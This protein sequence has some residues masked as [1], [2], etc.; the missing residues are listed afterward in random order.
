MAKDLAKEISDF[1]ERQKKRKLKNLTVNIGKTKSIKSSNQINITKTTTM[2]IIGWRKTIKSFRSASNYILAKSDEMTD[3]FGNSI[4]KE[5]MWQVLQSWNI[6]D[7]KHKRQFMHMIYSFP[8]HI[9]NEEQA[10]EVLLQ[11]LEEI[12]PYN[13][14]V[15]AF[16]K[17]TKNLHAHIMVKTKSELDNKQLVINPKELEAMHKTLDKVALLNKLDIVLHSVNKDKIKAK[18]QE[19][20]S[21]KIPKKYY[22]RVPKWVKMQEKNEFTPLEISENT[23]KRLKGIGLTDDNILKFA[24]M[25][26]ENK[27]FAT[28]AINENHKIFG[29]K[30]SPNFSARKMDIK[31]VSEISSQ[32]K[33]IQEIDEKSR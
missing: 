16:H 21:V 12:F 20:F 30:E 26:F 10:K 1:I 33:S 3:N 6:E 11:G 15:F 9:K 14:F 5:D 18:E 22:K 2:K 25:Y 17:D 27:S 31:P 4:K 24:N 8:S 32:A 7:S 28:W 23:K 13:K 29:L 19:K